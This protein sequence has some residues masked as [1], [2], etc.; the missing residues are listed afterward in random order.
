MTVGAPG[1]GRELRGPQKGVKWCVSERPTHV[2]QTA[3]YLI[4]WMFHVAA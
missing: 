1:V 2:I 3:P 4:T